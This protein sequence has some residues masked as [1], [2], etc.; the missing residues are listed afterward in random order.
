M[1]V[2]I[3]GVVYYALA[4]GAQYLGLAYL[5]SITVSLILNLTS[6]FVAAFGMLL[7]KERPTPLQWLGVALNLV[8][9]VVYFHPQALGEGSP[10]GYIAAVVSLLANVF[11]A[12]LSRKMNVDGKLSPIPLTGV[13][14][15]IGALLMLLTG[16][17][18][19]G[20]PAISLQS[21]GI[22]LILAVVNTAFSFTIW[23]TILQTLTAMESSIINS[24]MM[25]QV[26][27]LA[28]IFLGER[29]SPQGMLGMVLV[30]AGTIIVQLRFP[31]KVRSPAV[32]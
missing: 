1:Q 32:D 6:L 13:S 22:L 23:N 7:I 4:Q 25:I 28:W 3:L 19:E 31:G 12:I 26:A 27:I 2:V 18:S 30:V 14:M 15:G 24:T 29:L 16:L 17:I 21:W 11:G 5:S 20:L 8:G 10:I 9:V